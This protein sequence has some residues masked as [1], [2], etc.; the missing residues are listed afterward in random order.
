MTIAVV[1]WNTRDLLDACLR[2]LQADHGAGR[3]DVVVVDNGSV[4]GS[5]ALVRAA[6]PWAKVIER[7]D[8]P[9]FGAAVNDAAGRTRTPFVVAANADVAVTPGALP[10]LLDAAARHPRAGI[11]AP[12]LVTPDGVTQHS[13]HPFPSLRTAAA[14]DLGLGRLVP[15]LRNRLALERHVDAAIQRP[16][17]WAHGA[18]LLVRRETWD[19]VG[20]FDPEMWLYAEDLDLC[21][22]ARRAGWATWYE[23]AATVTHHVS[24]ATEQAWGDARAER[25]Q[26]AAYAWMNS[27]LGPGRTRVIAGLGMLGG[28]ARVAALGLATRLAPSRYGWR[29]DRARRRH[30]LHRAALHG[31]DTP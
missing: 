30:E 29:R 20:G 21:W 7:P 12:R 4:D 11:F 14:V 8:N 9:G 18:F 23:P 15:G 10:A 26:R 16:V 24:A 28:G 17:D 2:S 27:R 6:H 25:A 19:A 3:A 13:L 1:S 31:G 22:R 5:A